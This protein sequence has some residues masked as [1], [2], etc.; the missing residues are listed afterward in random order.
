MFSLS[1]PLPTSDSVTMNA[2][3]R[4]SGPMDQAESACVLFGVICS[5]GHMNGEGDV[6]LTVLGLTFFI[7]VLCLRLSFIAETRL[8]GCDGA[9]SMVTRL[10]ELHLES[11]PPSS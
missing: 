7:S 9:V 4:L 2:A 5:P 11:L 6:I 8:D 3:P 1:T 10:P